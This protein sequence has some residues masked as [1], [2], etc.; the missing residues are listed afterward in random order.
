[1]LT[2]LFA[3]TAGGWLKATE[4]EISAALWAKWTW[5]ELYY[6]RQTESAVP[7]LLALCDNCY[8]CIQVSESLHRQ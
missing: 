1:L 8:T 5:E 6:V 2:S 4:W 3:A 7:Y